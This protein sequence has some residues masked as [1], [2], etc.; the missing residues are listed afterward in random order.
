VHDADSPLLVAFTHEAMM[1]ISVQRSV[2][3]VNKEITHMAE[4][5][6]GQLSTGPGI[7][8]NA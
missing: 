2:F 8:R 7:R 1:S 4:K 5:V 3:S 6:D